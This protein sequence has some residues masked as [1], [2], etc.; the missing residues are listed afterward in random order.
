MNQN[1]NSLPLQSPVADLRRVPLSTLGASAESPAVAGL[2][3]RVLAD[4]NSVQVAA[5]NSRL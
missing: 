3:Q 5:F 4:S 1:P 2:L